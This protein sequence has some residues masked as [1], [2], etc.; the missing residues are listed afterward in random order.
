MAVGGRTLGPDK[1]AGGYCPVYKQ[2]R[3]APALC[4]P[5]D[6]KN[7]IA[8]SNSVTIYEGTAFEAPT[9]ARRASNARLVGLWSRFCTD[10]HTP[11]HPYPARTGND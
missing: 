5:A 11:S 8:D 2:Y 6:K 1:E 3:T 9:S 7:P 4:A 10:N